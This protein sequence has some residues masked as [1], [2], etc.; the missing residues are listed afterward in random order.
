M[1][2]WE[3]AEEVAQATASPMAQ[4]RR[5]VG[6]R[7]PALPLS[8]E[9]LAEVRGGAAATLRPGPRAWGSGGEKSR[10]DWGLRLRL[11]CPL[12]FCPSVTSSYLSW[13]LEWAP[14][15]LPGTGQEV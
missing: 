5:V 8:W 1:V 10:E 12:L 11:L 9:S 3:E 14:H 2:G 15:S 13:S 6:G 7:V 4:G